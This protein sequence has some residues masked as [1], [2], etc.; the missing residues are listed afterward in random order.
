MADTIKELLEKQI[1]ALDEQINELEGV[2]RVRKAEE[3][4]ITADMKSIRA[5]KRNLE[6]VK[7]RFGGRK[8]RQRKA[9]EE[10]VSE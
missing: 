6:N 1:T 9:K 2:Y 4:K 5:M 8:T 7:N 10:E 3:E